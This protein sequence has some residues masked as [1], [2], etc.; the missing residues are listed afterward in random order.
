MDHATLTENKGLNSWDGYWA[1]QILE[2]DM[3]YKIKLYKKLFLTNT[4]V[5]QTW[6]TDT[7]LID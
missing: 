6:V 5:I 3:Q 7:S 4:A 1:M 2:A